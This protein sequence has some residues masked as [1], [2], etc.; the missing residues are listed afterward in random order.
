M[1]YR[2]NPLVAALMTQLRSKKPCGTETIALLNLSGK[3]MS[4]KRSGDDLFYEQ[5]FAGIR[6]AS[7]AL[8]ISVDEIMATPETAERTASRILTARGIHGIL[9]FP[10][11]YAPAPDSALDLSR[12]TVVQIGFSGKI[13]FHRVVSDYAHD[14]DLA[15]KKAREAGI[16]KLG[17]AVSSMRDRSTDYSWSSR[18]LLDTA[19]HLRSAHIP[20][21][22]KFGSEYTSSEFLAWFERHKPEAILVAGI[23]EY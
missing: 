9:L 10:S 4:K 17:F 19:Q 16:K 6:I 23:S 11:G 18:F 22:K 5:L 3:S 12:F 21:V 20:F 7:E 8:G 13:P 1:G 15:L 14:I 2:P